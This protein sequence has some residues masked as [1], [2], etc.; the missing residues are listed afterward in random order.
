MSFK[1]LATVTAA[2]TA[3]LGLGYLVDGGLMV[4]R[5]RIEPTVSV[6]LFCR[7]IGALYVG[8]AVMLFLARNTSA[9]EART[10]LCAGAAVITTS[11]ALL[12]VYELSAGRVGPGMLVSIAIEALLAF[13][14]I[15]ILAT[16][17]HDTT[18]G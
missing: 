5:W 4:G 7:R 13:G 17:R 16:R 9:S 2:V 1:T 15:W 14:Y 8:L 6:L 10:A 3:V 18:A 12:G 11:L